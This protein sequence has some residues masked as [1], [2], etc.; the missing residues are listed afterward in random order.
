[1]RRPGLAVCVTTFWYALLLKLAILIGS[2]GHSLVF[3]LAVTCAPFPVGF[4]PSFGLFALPLSLTFWC[5]VARCTWARRR[6]LLP[7][8]LLMQYG[9]SGIECAKL[10]SAYTDNPDRGSAHIVPYFGWLLGAWALLFA[11]GQASLWSAWI[12]DSQTDPYMPAAH[13]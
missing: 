13:S 5:L 8:L 4:T 7:V 6:W 3:P 1:M 2:A 9:V 12:R 10:F 11:V